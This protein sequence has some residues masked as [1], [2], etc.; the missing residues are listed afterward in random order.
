[1]APLK[2][3][4]PSTA[5]TRTED[6]VTLSPALRARLGERPVFSLH[7]GLSPE[8]QY[9]H[10]AAQCGARQQAESCAHRPSS[11]DRGSRVPLLTPRRPGLVPRSNS[12]RTPSA[13]RIARW[14][15]LRLSRDLTLQVDRF[16]GCRSVQ[17]EVLPLVRISRVRE[18]DAVESLSKWV[19]RLDAVKERP[20][21]NDHY[22]LGRAALLP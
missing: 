8:R 22:H 13:K 4:S 21:G 11:F 2:R 7:A 9:Q 18:A 1:M 17:R 6:E 12:Y 5:E 16:Q 14:V 15:G 19:Q 10:P 20:H 3:M